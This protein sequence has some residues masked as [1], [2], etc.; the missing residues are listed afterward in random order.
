[1]ALSRGPLPGAG[2]ALHFLTRQPRRRRS[3]D[4]VGQPLYLTRPG[5]VVV[6]RA[7]A[8]GG[9]Q[10]LVLMSTAGPG[11][12]VVASDVEVETALRVMIVPS[13]DEEEPVDHPTVWLTRVWRRW[14]GGNQ[15]RLAQALTAVVE[16][17]T[18]AVELTDEVIER[19]VQQTHTHR[20]A[21]HRLIEQF[22]YAGLLTR[23]GPDTVALTLPI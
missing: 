10:C 16:P 4:A 18:L 6:P 22:E 5:L 9:W 23:A 20:E 11:P 17:H 15:P 2:G 3:D 13:Y 14:P 7:R 19:L 21:L 8:A 1:M 12:T